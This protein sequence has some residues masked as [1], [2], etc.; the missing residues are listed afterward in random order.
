MEREE[1][2]SQANY[3]DFLR[4][5]PQ[6]VG[7]DDSKTEFSV[8]TSTFKTGRPSKQYRISVW[9][10]MYEPH[11]QNIAM[12]VDT[13]GDNP[14]RKCN[15]FIKICDTGLK[16]YIFY[17]RVIFSAEAFAAGN[18]IYVVFSFHGEHKLQ[19]ENIIQQ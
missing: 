18:L 8:L 3:S 17:S 19:E 2:V 9:L 16:S 15:Y 4:H 11:Y 5:S 7:T 6:K 13:T 12:P 10:K 14:V 1:T